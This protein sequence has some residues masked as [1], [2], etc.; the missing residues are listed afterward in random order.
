MEDILPLKKALREA[1][2]IYAELKKMGAHELENINIGGGLSVEYSQHNE[3][4]MHNVSI[5][6]F[7]NDVVFVIKTIM[8]AKNVAH[9][10]IFTESGRYIVASHAILITPVLELFSQDFQLKSLRL[11]Q[12]N[13]PLIEEL[14]DLLNLLNKKNALEYLHDAFDHM[15]SLFSLFELGY[16]DLQDRSNAE[17]LAHQIIKKVLTL[18]KDKPIKELLH[19]QHELQE[20]YLVNSSFFQS[21]PDYW[22]L[23]QRFPVMPLDHLDKPALRA[24][25]LWDITCDS[26]GEI[27]FDTESGLYLHDVNLEEEEYFLA[28]F[29]IGAYQETLGMNHNLFSHPSECT[30]ILDEYSYKIEKTIESDSILSILT[31]LGY[32]SSQILIQLKNNLSNALFTT[33]E[34]KN[35]TLSKLELYVHQ[36]S[37]LNSI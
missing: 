23:G 5:E 36:N 13:P 12:V 1:G 35:D 31:E 27:P 10:N 20:R 3:C 4:K 18:M 7:S 24:A 26:D 34:E 32:D 16:I 14:H 25:S 30:I 37:Y 15:Q 8:D 9:P 33:E 19:L 11:K 22:G 2:N 28:F 21:L 17:I 6:E 29:N